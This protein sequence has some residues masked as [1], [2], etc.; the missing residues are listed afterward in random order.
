MPNNAPTSSLFLKKAFDEKA[1][2]VRRTSY[3]CSG[4]SCCE[5]GA[6]GI[7]SS[8]TSWTIKDWEEKRAN[9]RIAEQAFME[10]WGPWLGQEETLK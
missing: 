5:Y 3:K 9:T 1:I 6:L 2:P 4:I 10:E 7:E 8:Y